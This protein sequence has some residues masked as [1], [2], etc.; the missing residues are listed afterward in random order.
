MG[1]GQAPTSGRSGHGEFRGRERNTRLAALGSPGSGREGPWGLGELEL[2]GAGAR[3]SPRGQRV[4]H[5]STRTLKRDLKL[6]TYLKTSWG[7]CSARPFRP[8]PKDDSGFRKPSAGG[9]GGAAPS[10]RSACGRRGS[11]PAAEQPSPLRRLP[12]ARFLGCPDL[13]AAGILFFTIWCLLLSFLQPR[14][15]LSQFPH[16]KWA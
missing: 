7:T 13:G 12:G 16:L 1:P 4:T 2:G 10:W 6:R 14:S 9:R 15:F 11:G 8:K 5:S 3:G